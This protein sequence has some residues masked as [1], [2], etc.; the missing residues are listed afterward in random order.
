MENKTEIFKEEYTHIPTECD[1]CIY[2]SNCHAQC[3]DKFKYTLDPDYSYDDIEDE[4]EYEHDCW[5]E[6]EVEK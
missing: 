2:Q 1:C 4:E 6:E 5:L 3:E